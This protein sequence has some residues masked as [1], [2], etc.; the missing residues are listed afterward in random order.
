MIFCLFIS[1]FFFNYLGLMTMFIIV[2]CNK[3]RNK[4]VVYWQ[5]DLMTLPRWSKFRF[6]NFCFCQSLVLPMLYFFIDNSM[7]WVFTHIGSFCTVSG[8]H[9]E[10]TWSKIKDILE[11]GKSGVIVSLL[12][13]SQRLSD[14]FIYV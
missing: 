6:G 11:M 1:L 12:A 10:R 2:Y 5:Q 13:A 3:Q 14:V 8:V 7:F 9:M 4:T